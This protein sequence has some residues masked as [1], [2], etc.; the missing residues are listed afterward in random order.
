MNLHSRHHIQHYANQIAKE[1][2]Q[3]L[4]DLSAIP[5]PVNISEQKQR[6]MQKEKLANDF[7]DALK[8]FQINQR[9]S[10]QKEKESVI[11]ARANSGKNVSFILFSIFS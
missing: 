5:A 9:T 4:K 1:T 10:A 7:T 11:R 3:N 6:R 2:N 8:N